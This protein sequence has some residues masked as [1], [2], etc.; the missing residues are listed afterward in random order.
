MGAYQPGQQLRLDAARQPQ[1]Q[2]STAANRRIAIPECNV[3]LIIEV[4]QE[5]VGLRVRIL[6]D[7]TM[8]PCSILLLTKS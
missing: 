3:A 8:T 1:G 2:L 4:V 7:S 5:V 6:T